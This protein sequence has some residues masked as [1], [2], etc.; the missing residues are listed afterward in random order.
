[1]ANTDTYTAKLPP[2]T[3]KPGMQVVFEAINTSTGAAV[4]NVVVSA[5]A[6]YG[7]DL[8][9]QAAGGGGGTL[10]LGPLEPLLV[11]VE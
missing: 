7:V 5:V 2:I 3:L 9:A 11:R 4:P 6:I 10:E 1:M 8:S